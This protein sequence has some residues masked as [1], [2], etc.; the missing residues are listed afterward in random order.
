[1]SE[2]VKDWSTHLPV[3]LVVLDENLDL[4]DASR[5]AFSMF[6]I[7]YR[8]SNKARSLE[9]LS[10]YLLGSPSFVSIIGAASLKLTRLG[11]QDR[12]RW[13]DG[14]RVFDIDIGTMPPEECLRYGLYFQNVTK[15]IEFERSREVTRN[16][17][18]QMIDSLPLGIVVVDCDMCITAMNRVQQEFMALHGSPSSLLSAVGARLFELL[19]E[20]ESFPWQDVAERLF[21]ERKPINDL[22]YSCKIDGDTRTFSVNVIPLQEESGEVIGAMHITEEITETLRLQEEARESEVLSARLET[23]QHTV[24]T[25]NHV[26]NNKL[27]GIMCSIEVVRSAGEPV[28]ESK[29]KVLADV[30]DEVDKIARFIRDLAEIKEIKITDYLK[31]GEKM[32]DV[33]AE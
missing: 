3:P 16:Y 4:I 14:E 22:K 1:M 21:V 33:Y 26:I 7:R 15:Q 9:E 8:S 13:N 2:N 23:L 12:V 29:Q 27:M 11:S 25:L 18:E 28:P 30:M 32:L 17:L 6:R 24:V 31:G 19:P 5:A 10:N 20:H